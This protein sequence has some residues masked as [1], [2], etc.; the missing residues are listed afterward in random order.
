MEIKLLSELNHYQYYMMILDCSDEELLSM[1][2]NK[3]DYIDAPI[4]EERYQVYDS[5]NILETYLFDIETS[6]VIYSISEKQVISNT[7]LEVKECL[8]EGN[9]ELAK[10]KIVALQM[11]FGL[12]VSFYITLKRILTENLSLYEILGFGNGLND[13]YDNQRGKKL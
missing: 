12:D 11:F 8:W 3:F 4:V 1:Q 7:I 6:E 13:I 10:L 9:I 5:L 2:M